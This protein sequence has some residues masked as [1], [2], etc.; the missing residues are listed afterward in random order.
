MNPYREYMSKSAMGALRRAWLSQNQMRPEEAAKFSK[1]VERLTNWKLR[2]SGLT[3]KTKAVVDID[4]APGL[5]GQGTS[6]SMS[7]RIDHRPEQKVLGG[8]LPSKHP[9]AGFGKHTI[10][11]EGGKNVVGKV[12]LY[13]IDP[14]F[15][16]RGLGS[17]MAAVTDD[18]MEQVGAHTLK[19]TVINP[20]HVGGYRERLGWETKKTQGIYASGLGHRNVHMMEKQVYDTPAV[21]RDRFIAQHL[22]QNKARSISELMSRNSV[23]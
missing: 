10:H 14:K 9:F 16:G 1:A 21:A 6:K 17:R 5:F 15:Q 20:A 4:Q 11:N 3:G 2:K 12:D 13:E 22:D 18:V 19:S 7:L 8:L 23:H